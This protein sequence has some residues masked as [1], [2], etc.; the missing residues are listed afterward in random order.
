MRSIAGRN[1]RSSSHDHAMGRYRYQGSP[2][3]K[4]WRC[5]KSPDRGVCSCR[6]SPWPCF[7]I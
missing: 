7:E 2:H 1:H 4:A 6:S 3:T 5:L